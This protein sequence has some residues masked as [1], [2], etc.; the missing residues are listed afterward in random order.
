MC[1][2][3]SGRCRSRSGTPYNWLVGT[4]RIGRGRRSLAGAGL[5]VAPLALL[6]L[7]LV[8]AGLSLTS[9]ALLHLVPVVVVAGV[10]GVWL[11]PAPPAAAA[12]PA[13]WV[14]RPPF[15]PPAGAG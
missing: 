3:S 13:N 1:R 5:G 15:H 12:A 14:L 8:P 4:L 2:G 11:G 10:G 7:A 6:T 9:V